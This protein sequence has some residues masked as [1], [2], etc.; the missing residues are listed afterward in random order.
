MREEGARVER[1]AATGR[2]GNR[3]KGRQEGEKALDRKP[4][5]ASSEG[6]KWMWKRRPI[7]GLQDM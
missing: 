1:T 5:R 6:K 7:A 2:E 3:R 4:K